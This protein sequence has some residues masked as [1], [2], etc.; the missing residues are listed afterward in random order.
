MKIYIFILFLQLLGYLARQYTYYSYDKII[1]TFHSLA[2]TCPQFIKIDTSQSRYRLPSAGQCGDR[3]LPCENL[4]V[5][6]TDFQTMDISR[7]QIF[8]SGELNGDDRI[9][10]T[11]LTELAVYFC[12]PSN[13]K[14]PWVI[15]L[16]KERYFVF[17]P[18]TNAYGYSKNQKEDLVYTPV[19]KTDVNPL[20]DFPYFFHSNKTENKCMQTI[21]ARTVNELFREHLFAAVINFRA[22]FNGIGYPWGNKIHLSKDNKTS[23]ENPD[24]S[25]YTAIGQVLKTYSASSTTSKILMKDYILTDIASLV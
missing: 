1:E 3:N 20:N 19:N 11:V 17:T 13:Q 8:I 16:L 10:P 6:M 7:P 4:I 14:E 24:F 15:N 25:M 21:T 23:T 12:D 22:G 5:F 9:G 2:R 18:M